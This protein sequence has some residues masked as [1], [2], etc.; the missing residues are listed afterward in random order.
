MNTPQPLGG[1]IVAVRYPPWSRAMNT[2]QPLGG[3]IVAVRY[4][5]W[6]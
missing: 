5:P 2:P 6:S 4:P 3:A 1:T